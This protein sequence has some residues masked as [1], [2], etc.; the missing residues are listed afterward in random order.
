MW[1][2]FGGSLATA[3]AVLARWPHL[4]ALGAARRGALTAVVAESTRGVADVPARVE[5]IRAAARRWAQF[6]DRHLDLDALAWDVTEHLADLTAAGA[7]VDRATEQ[8]VRYWEQLFGEDP[9]SHLAAGHGADHRAHG[10]G[11]PRRR[12]SELVKFPVYEGTG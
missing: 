7:R 6:W 9:L 4:S 8:A 2:G 1:N 12:G 11:V 10:A 5:R 3:K